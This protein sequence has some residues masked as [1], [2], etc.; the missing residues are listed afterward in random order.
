MV[1]HL[2]A[3]NNMSQKFSEYLTETGFY[4]SNIENPY[5]TIYGNDIIHNKKKNKSKS[6]KETYDEKEKCSTELRN[7]KIRKLSNYFQIF[8]SIQ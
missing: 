7:K 2:V 5:K 4:L 1:E 8:N 6:S 3:E